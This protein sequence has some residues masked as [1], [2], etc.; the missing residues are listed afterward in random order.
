M[1]DEIARVLRALNKRNPLWLAAL[2]ALVFC[3]AE[4][5]YGYATGSGEVVKDGAEWLY[6]VVI[7]GL[8]AASLGRP[9]SIERHATFLLLAIF[10]IGGFEGTHDAFAAILHPTGEGV[11]PLATNVID[12]SGCVVEAIMLVPLR[13]SHNPVLE[14]TW[15]SARNSVVASLAGVAVTIGCEVF[16]LRWPRIAVIALES[17]LAFQAAFVVAR[18]VR[19]RRN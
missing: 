13:C 11:E 3:A 2:A 5:F 10:I 19:A 17:L 16:T 15:L 18:D 9:R 7:Y 4:C 6:D 12:V 14:A 1:A 8:A